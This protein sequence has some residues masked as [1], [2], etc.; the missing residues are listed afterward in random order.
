MKRKLNDENIEALAPKRKRYLVYDSIV[1]GLAVRVS[2]KGKKTFVMVAR[3]NGNKHPTR[4]SLGVVGRIN[5]ERIREKAQNILRDPRPSSTDTFGQIA[6]RYFQHIERLRRSEEV[7]R[8][9]RRD[10]FPGWES[11][12][13]SSITK[14]DV[15]TIVDAVKSRGKPSA[16]HHVL[17]YAR[18]LFNYAIARDI[19]DHSPCDRLKPS[20]LIGPKGTRHRVLDDDEIRRLWAASEH[21]GY[22]YGPLWQLL[23]VTGQRRGEVAHARWSEFDLRTRL[24]TVPSERFKSSAAQLVPLSQLAIDILAKLPREG[25][26][27]FG[28]IDGFSK[29]KKRLDKTMGNPTPFVIHD[30]RRTVRT[31]LSSLRVPSEVA[32]MVIGHGKKGLARVYDQHHYLPEMRDAL[33]R[34][35]TSLRSMLRLTCTDKSA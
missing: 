3:F 22:P 24:W 10:L 27:L 12:V 30:L 33:E 34:W 9:I 28:H 26:Y 8:C 11:K 2:V 6:E 17:A 4:R 23:L 7:E 21:I 1:P 5:L 25:D 20:T 31:R 32:E 19:I 14:R 16:A 13:L 18:G 29:A 15:I 35:E